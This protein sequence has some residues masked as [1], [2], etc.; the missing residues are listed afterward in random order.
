[1]KKMILIAAA[2]LVAAT[3]FAQEYNATTNPA[4]SVGL[5]TAVDL[6]AAQ[7]AAKSIM[8]ALPWADIFGT[9][10]TLM[11]LYGF[12]FMRKAAKMAIE[13]RH[14]EKFL[15]LVDWA[16][17]TAEAVTAAAAKKTAAQKSTEMLGKLKATLGRELTDSEKQIALARADMLAAL[18]HQDAE[19][20]SMA[21]RQ[22]SLALQPNGSAVIR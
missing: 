4:L 7:P 2:L 15:P 5:E 10:A 9:L 6:G 1:M 13:K 14:L 3:L 16:F 17:T 8:A 22:P 20:P 12:P 21:A 11:L 18:D 19:A